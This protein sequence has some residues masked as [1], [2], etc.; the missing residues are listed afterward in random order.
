MVLILR[1]FWRSSLKMARTSPYV[2]LNSWTVGLQCYSVGILDFPSYISAYI[3]PSQEGDFS[4][5]FRTSKTYIITS[6]RGKKR[7]VIRTALNS[8]DSCST[9]DFVMHP[10]ASADR[11]LPIIPRVSFS[12]G[13]GALCRYIDIIFEYFY[14]IYLYRFYFF[15]NRQQLL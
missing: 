15:L 4:H 11:R 6:W 2:Y 13:I 3:R 7:E 8:N 1:N 9:W 14:H 10:L 12:W 5:G